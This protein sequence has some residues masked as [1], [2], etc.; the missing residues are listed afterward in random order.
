[1][2]NKKTFNVF[3][4]QFTSPVH[5]A[6][7]MDDYGKSMQVVHSDTLYAALT[8]TLAKTGQNINEGGDLGFDVSSLF[9]YYEVCQQTDN[10]GKDQY[11]CV[12]FLPRPGSA[13]VLPP[14][15]MTWHK[16][17]KKVKWLDLNYFKR[18]MHGEMIFNHQSVQHIQGEYLT[19]L[20]LPPDGI[21]R[22]WVSPRVN[23]PRYNPDNN[24][25]SGQPRPFYMERLEFVQ[26]AGLWFLALGSH[27]NLKILEKAL[28]VLGQEGLGTDRNVGN[29]HF[30]FSRDTIE[31]NLPEADTYITLGL[32]IPDVKSMNGHNL[33]NSLKA[34]RILRRGGWITTP[35]YNTFRKNNIYAFDIGS[36][37]GQSNGNPG[38][39]AGRIVNLT[40]RGDYPNFDHHIYR[41]GRA[42]IL[43]FK[44]VN[45]D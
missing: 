37:Y 32:Y 26:H 16:K 18:M 1:M 11:R 23:V 5:F 12:Y 4:L 42:I 40:P 20:S 33:N 28:T 36:I 24:E 27:E 15:L 44:I 39:I 17:I 29:G 45:N 3:K 14:E 21:V 2:S 43:P 35:P 38:D 10:T 22:S 25:L 7:E 30:I 13:T 41:Y 6:D 19:E 34:F 8:S 31:L 9:P